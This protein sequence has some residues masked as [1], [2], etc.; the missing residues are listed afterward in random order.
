MGIDVQTFARRS[1]SKLMAKGQRERQILEQV[2]AQARAWADEAGIGAFYD[3]TFV[4]DRALAIQLVPAAEAVRFDLSQAGLGA[5]LRTSNAG[6]GYHAAVVDMLDHLAEACGLTWDWGQ[7][8]DR[9]FDETGYALTRDVKALQ[10]EHGK[11]LRNLMET[12]LEHGSDNGSFCLPWGLGAGDD[13]LACP[14]GIK[15]LSW[16]LAVV[17]AD[18]DVRLKLAREFFPWWERSVDASF[19]ENMLRCLLWQHVEWRPPE[20]EREARTLMMIQE[21]AQQLKKLAGGVPK[22]LRAALKELDAAVSSGVAPPPDGIGYRRRPIL[23]VL[24]DDWQISLPGTLVEDISENGEA[25]HY[26]GTDVALRVSAISVSGAKD[27]PPVWPTIVSDAG[28]VNAH[29]LS[30]RVAA[31]ERDGEAVSQFAVVAHEAGEHL[32]ILMLTLTAPDEAGLAVFNSWLDTVR[33]NE[34]DHRRLGRD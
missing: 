4:S 7:G 1:S 13:Q 29:G 27:D 30:R 32:N 14:I 19:F 23:R 11:F 5:G 15:P 18:N 17:E 21:A 31:P 2:D 33:W 3:S 10:R 34:A 12:S 28:E 16:R 25:A 20:T 22:D 9:S 24:F 26:A 8:G 6:P